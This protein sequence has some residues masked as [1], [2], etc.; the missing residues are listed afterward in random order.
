[1]E[2]E[3]TDKKKVQARREGI[4]M[5]AESLAEYEKTWKDI[6]ESI[7]WCSKHPCKLKKK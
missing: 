5:N 3:I 7:Q 1:M 4:S 6:D 2:V